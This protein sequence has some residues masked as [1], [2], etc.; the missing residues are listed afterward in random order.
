VSVN[1]VP[2]V[3]YTEKLEMGYR[4][5]DAHFTQPLFPFGHGLSYT[6]FALS[7][8]V[9]T[10]KISDGTQPIKVQFSVQNTGQV[11]GAEVAQVYLQLPMS[12]GEPP[13]R[14]VGFQKVF[15]QPGEKRQI[16]VTIS[17]AA[18][19]HPLGIW[20]S[21]KQSWTTLTGAYAVYLA[22]S[23]KNIVGSGL[24][25]VIVPSGS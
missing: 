23:S 4:W 13:K 11:A 7:E 19:N 2:T 14:L 25:K 12:A 22:T 8:L 5:Y 9:V 18:S 3:T 21:A 15:L 6:T 17:P 1:G 20:D 10:P 16:E 24:V